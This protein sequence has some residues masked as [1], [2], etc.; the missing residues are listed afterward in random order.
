MEACW[1]IR[2]LCWSEWWPHSRATSCLYCF[3]FPLVC[4][5]WDWTQDLAHVRQ[6]F[7]IELHPLSLI[8]W[9][10]VSLCSPG[11]HFVDQ[12]GLK[13]RDPPISASQVLGLWCT[14]IPCPGFCFV[15]ILVPTPRGSLCRGPWLIASVAKI[16]SHQEIEIMSTAPLMVPTINQGEILP[17]FILGTHWIY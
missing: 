10:R 17:Q 16:P 13:L 4:S 9:D 3:P 1:P 8:F 15:V 12:P 2:W 7:Y 5:V 6:V 11:T 14:T